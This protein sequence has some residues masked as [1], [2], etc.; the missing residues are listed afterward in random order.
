MFTGNAVSKRILSAVSGTAMPT[1]YSKRFTALISPVETWLS[2][3]T[4]TTL[5]GARSALEAEIAKF[6][7]LAVR[8]PE[9]VIS[10]E[11]VGLPFSG[12]EGRFA[13][14]PLT[15]LG[16][17]RFGGASLEEAE[18]DLWTSCYLLVL[19]YVA[20]RLTEGLTIKTD[21]IV[22]RVD[23]FYI[24]YRTSKAANT[25]GGSLVERP[26]P[27]IVVRAAYVA[28]K[29]G[30]A[31]RRKHGSNDLFFVAHRQG[32]SVPEESSVRQ[33]LEFFGRRTGASSVE[34]GGRRAVVPSE[35]RRFFV[36]MWVNYYEYAGK[37]ESLR[38]FL[39]HAWITT[40]VRYGIRKNERARM[41]DEQLELSVKVLARKLLDGAGALADVPRSIFPFLQ[42]LR[43]RALPLA[44]MLKELRDYAEDQGLALFPM[45]WGYCLWHHSAGKYAQCLDATLRRTGMERIDADR[46]CPGC[47][48]CHNLL[49]DHVFDPFYETGMERHARIASNPRAS[50]SLRAAA[51][52]FVELATRVLSTVI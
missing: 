39:N 46:S 27:E 41:S 31:A 7:A 47:D 3:R 9:R 2:S 24:R 10:V 45:A 5:N 18:A 32:A 4:A 48:G 42:A 51:T 22:R 1:L 28:K 52:R 16:T 17:G 20:P 34:G 33:R 37:Y 50:S 35:M 14:W 38:R 12:Q 36:T 11:K 49:R 21:C 26:C 23:G 30:A 25:E 44:E 8:P 40:T 19:A 15:T 43:V 6:E 13:P 29:L